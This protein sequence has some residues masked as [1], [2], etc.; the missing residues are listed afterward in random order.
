MALLIFS[1]IPVGSCVVV[2]QLIQ[3]TQYFVD[4]FT[5]QKTGTCSDSFFTPDALV[6]P[7]GIYVLRCI[8]F[9]RGRK[10][11]SRVVAGFYV[12]LYD[13]YL[14]LHDFHLILYD[15]HVILHGFYLIS[16]HF[17]MI[18]CDFHMILFG[19]YLI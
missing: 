6:G 8:F 3:Y 2:F 14:I 4:H 13:F 1:Q 15:F 16:F 10:L 12:I 17:H 18:L 11:L 9:H 19:F 5:S 7:L